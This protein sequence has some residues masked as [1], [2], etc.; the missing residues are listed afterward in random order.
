MAH[1]LT[2]EISLNSF[3]LNQH[4]AEA[5]GPQCELE[6]SCAER[7]VVKLWTPFM[8]TILR[9]NKTNLIE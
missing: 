6:E 1:Q 3:S 5:L 7:G 2:M 8:G 4:S 9:K